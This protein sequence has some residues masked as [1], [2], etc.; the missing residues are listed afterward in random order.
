MNLSLDEK[1]LIGWR[2]WIAIPD[3]GI[4]QIKAKVDTGAKTSTLHAE[5]IRIFRKG[6][7]RFVRFKV[8][9]FQRNSEFEISAKCDLVEKRQVRSSTGIETIRPVI[10]IPI[11]MAGEMWPVEITLVNRDMMGFR[12]LLGRE[13]IRSRFI[14]DPER[15][16]LLGKA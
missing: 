5:D 2:E 10:L 6:S 8:R 16:F 4:H 11:L 14:V 15:S 9:P 7:K 3:L 12:M 13:A 1:R